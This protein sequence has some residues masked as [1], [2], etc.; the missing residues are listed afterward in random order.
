MIYAVEN[1]PLCW[2]KGN[3]IM[4]SKEA[5]NKISNKLEEALASIIAEKEWEEGSYSLSFYSNLAMPN[6]I[7]MRLR[8]NAPEHENKEID[9][10]AREVLK[11]IDPNLILSPC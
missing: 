5:F 9:V 10:K 8:S 11:G 4:M 7:E 1:Q 2:D 3:F 6:W